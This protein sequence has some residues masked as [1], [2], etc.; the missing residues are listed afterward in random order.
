MA[1]PVS[2]LAGDARAGGWLVGVAATILVAPVLWLAKYQVC[3]LA[4]VGLDDYWRQM[5][6]GRTVGDLRGLRIAVGPRNSGMTQHAHAILGA[7]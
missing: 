3:G 4:R 6:C 5:V 1:G 7:T 2:V